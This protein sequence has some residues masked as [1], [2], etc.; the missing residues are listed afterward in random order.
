MKKGKT[1][2]LI[3]WESP[4]QNI[5]NKVARILNH[6][7]SG[8]NV[9]EVLEQLYIDSKYYPSERLAY[10]ISKRGNPYPVRYDRIHGIPWEGRMWCGHNP[11]LYARQ[12]KNLRVEINKTSQGHFDWDEIV[13]PKFDH[14]KNVLNKK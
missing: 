10:S 9:H 12:V 1:A 7:T 3:T 11:Y 5:K 8:S 14:L 13:R 2:W 4:N 6:R